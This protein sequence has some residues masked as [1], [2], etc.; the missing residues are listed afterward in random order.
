[1]TRAAI[2]ARY[3]TD[4]Q[5]EASIDDQVRL[6]RELAEREGWDV[7]ECYTDHGISGSNL[8]RPGMQMMLHDA[9]A[10]HFD[11]IVAESLDRMSRD[12]EDIAHVHKRLSFAGIAIHTLSEGAINELHIG[13]KGTMGA[14][15]LKDLA[16]KTRRGLRGRVEAGKSGG[17]NAYGYDV[18][19]T[20]ASDGTA[21]RGD[22]KINPVQAAVV[23][24]I[25]T[26]YAKGTSPRAI[27]HAL[28]EEGIAGPSGKG[29]G[30]STIH[31]N[32]QRGTGILNNELY[33]GRLVWNRLRYLKEP[34]TGKRVSRLNPE[35]NWIIQEVPELRI[36][37]QDLWD[38]VK[39]RQGDLQAR[40]DAHP[41]KWAYWDR[42][43]PRF[44]FTG[45]MRCGV[46]GGGVINFNKVRIGCA[47]ARNKGTC[48]NKT[49]M[50]RS[51]L[52]ALVLDGLQ[53]H[54]MDPALVDVFCQTYTNHMNKL[55]ADHNAGRT[56]KQAELDS[57][58]RDLDRLIQA[59]I[60]GVPGAQVKDRIAA[61]EQRKDTLSHE[62]AHSEPAPVSLHPNMAAYYREAVADLREALLAPD[63]RD[64][65]TAVVRDLIDAI[66]LTPVELEGKKTLSV[67]L[68]GRLAGILSL[69]TGA[70]EPLSED[71]P[72]V[73]VAKL[74]AGAG[75]E[76]A[77][78][79]L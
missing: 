3:S 27:A 76:P 56:G 23:T 34:A 70:A 13:L 60:D 45:L 25:F 19:H 46:C 6:A 57:V 72:P 51:D 71:A 4:L 21:Q 73:R 77:T 1:M 2:Y 42:R 37:D 28:N 30:P 14:L 36:V 66:V 47:T 40:R 16:D 55:A 79:R 24:R 67:Q 43:R 59:I 15:Y 9:A 52:E 17:G 7:V 61:L 38:Q 12:Q 54:L 49:T 44:L 48:S 39:A 22:R 8:R 20:T 65:A 18:V 11:I 78:F 50:L 53:H 58:T 63:K 62:L 75:F 31:G 26:A 5:R 35:S 29:W 68:V 32:R 33:I 69:A 74:V 64:E 41:D 10:G